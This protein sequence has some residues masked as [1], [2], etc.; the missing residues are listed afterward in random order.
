MRIA[1]V[2]FF[3]ISCCC[4]FSSSLFF[5]WFVVRFS[6]AIISAEMGNFG[7]GKK[8]Y[9][10]ACLVVGMEWKCIHISVVQGTTVSASLN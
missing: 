3:C 6:A 9:L 7:W 8:Y 4:F 1:P 5:C 2:V 10:I